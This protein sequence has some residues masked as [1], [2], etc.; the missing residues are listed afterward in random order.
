MF[1]RSLVRYACEPVNQS[2]FDQV[3]QTICEGKKRL[4]MLILVNTAC[5]FEKKY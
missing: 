2:K 4:G 3:L 5:Y 1:A